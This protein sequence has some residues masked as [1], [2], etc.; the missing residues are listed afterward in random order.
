MMVRDAAHTDLGLYLC[1]STRV[2]KFGLEL[3]TVKGP[4]DQQ[5]PP[6]LR[7]YLHALPALT[8]SNPTC[9]PRYAGRYPPPA[10]AQARALLRPSPRDGR[11]LREGYSDSLH[12]CFP[13]SPTKHTRQETK[14]KRSLGL[15]ATCIIGAAL[16]L[17]G[18]YEPGS[19]SSIRT[20][21]AQAQQMSQSEFNRWRRDRERRTKRLA[22]VSKTRIAWGKERRPNETVVIEINPPLQKRGGA[23]NT[24]VEW[25]FSYLNDVG[26]TTT[27]RLAQRAVILRWLPSMRAENIPIRVRRRL[28]G[29]GPGL[30]ARFDKQRTRIQE[31]YLGSQW[32][33]HEGR[34]NETIVKVF[35][36]SMRDG[37]IILIRERRDVE[38]L[39]ERAGIPAEEW[40]KNTTHYIA[41]NTTL[42]EKRWSELY[43][44]APADAFE[45]IAD[46]IL[47]I[48]G[49]YLVT[50]NTAY[51]QRRSRA[52]E[53]AFQTA[54]ALIRQ[55]IEASPRFGVKTQDILWGNEHKPGRKE[56]VQLTIPYPTT[57]GNPIE[58]EWLYTYVT[59][60]GQRTDS[61]W[62]EE[63]LSTWRQSLEREGIEVSLRRTPA[64]WIG[65]KRSPFAE[66]QATHQRI[67]LAWS[68]EERD[69]Q[70]ALHGDLGSRLTRHP[71]SIRT[72]DKGLD[73]LRRSG[74]PLD[75][76]E[77]RW[78]SEKLERE[79]EA[80]RAKT[81][82]IERAIGKKQRSG[83]QDPVL[84]VNG[85]YV[86]DGGLAG[87]TVRALQILNWVVRQ[88]L[89]EGAGA[90]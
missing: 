4:S 14:M 26:I 49:K 50:G 42:A 40:W 3:L 13:R 78:T 22:D 58:I 10:R 23:E 84:L 29:I 36:Q 37:S 83:V 85:E 66:D 38:R 63:L 45:G 33:A 39:V 88:H 56:I 15:V 65:G 62:I 11:G 46:P 17:F 47:L 51:R 41:A 55:A 16:W 53:R 21:E 28:L 79:A 35:V 9:V 59:N 12:P 77:E 75:H 67:I 80:A 74:M 76:S 1:G 57:E 30:P 72:K 86:I 54:N 2:P 48:D 5:L 89:E 82:W 8:G 19:R 87:G 43:A 24:E 32:Y 18:S 7:I 69:W 31:I 90:N 68:D 61:V 25:F 6:H 70:D 73:F 44:R 52:P 60:D 20:A 71:R 27:G 81:G 34:G 64:V